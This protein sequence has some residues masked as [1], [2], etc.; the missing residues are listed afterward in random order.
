MFKSGDLIKV[1]A[2]YIRREC[3]LATINGISFDK[4]YTVIKEHF[5][6][7]KSTLCVQ[8]LDN[9]GASR[10]RPSERYELYTERTDDFTEDST[11]YQSNKNWGVF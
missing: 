9:D 11:D 4:P 2:E 7:E 10:N 1:K 6:G 3:N 8:F 5:F